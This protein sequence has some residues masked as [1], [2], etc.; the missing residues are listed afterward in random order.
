MKYYSIILGFI[1]APWLANADQLTAT[2]TL[3]SLSSHVL[4]LDASTL[5]TATLV[6]DE[7]LTTAFALIDDRAA[8]ESW[9][10]ERK[11]QAREQ[12]RQT[13]IDVFNHRID[14]KLE[15]EWERFVIM[16]HLLWSQ[17]LHPTL[18]EDED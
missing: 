18:A 8:N 15:R 5:T 7:D 13:V 4:L 3:D 9:S 11:D 16:A 2:F 6:I 14:A 1:L 12:A 17:R 10:A